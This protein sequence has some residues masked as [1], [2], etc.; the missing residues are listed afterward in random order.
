MDILYS[1]I[2]A[3]EILLL[4]FTHEINGPVDIIQERFC[5]TVDVHKASGEV[6]RCNELIVRSIVQAERLQLVIRRIRSV[7]GE[8]R[9]DPLQRLTLVNHKTRIHLRQDFPEVSAAQLDILADNLQ[10]LWR[11]PDVADGDH[12]AVLPG[13]NMEVIPA[14]SGF[15]SSP[16]D[17]QAHVRFVGRLVIAEPKVPVYTIGA[18]L[19]GH[20]ADGL[21]ETADA[22]YQFHCQGIH[23]CPGRQVAVPVGI[24]P[25]LVVVQGQVLKES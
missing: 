8:R 22:V 2:Q 12:V 9:R 4:F 23:S 20:R 11:A 1:E 25:L 3:A 17:I 6:F 7:F 14:V 16:V 18:I 21:V 19:R 24:E 15:L 5:R 13:S 10:H